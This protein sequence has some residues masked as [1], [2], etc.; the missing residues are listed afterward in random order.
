MAN[1][2]KI[3]ENL[4]KTPCKSRSKTRA[5][6]CG[7]KKVHQNLVQNSIFSHTF[8]RLS[9]N[10]FTTTSPLFLSNLFHY[11]TDPTITIINN[12]IERNK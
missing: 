8:P 12:I 9:T 10:F 4:C 7:N 1:I 3:M 6:F 2:T 11:S 5:R